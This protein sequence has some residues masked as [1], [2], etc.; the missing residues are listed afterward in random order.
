MRWRTIQWKYQYVVIVWFN[1]DS[2][3]IRQAIVTLWN[4]MSGYIT[5]F[6]CD[7]SLFGAW[8]VYYGTARATIYLS[9]II[10]RFHIQFLR[11]CHEIKLRI[12]HFTC[13]CFCEHLIFRRPKRHDF[14]KSCSR[15]HFYRYKVSS[16]FHF[17]WRSDTEINLQKSPIEVGASGSHIIRW[18]DVITTVL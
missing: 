7:C 15:N 10:V 5:A 3:E 16:V 12:S 11:Y 17:L 4:P 2:R 9:K 14:P 18:R 8:C 6:K 1:I 13:A